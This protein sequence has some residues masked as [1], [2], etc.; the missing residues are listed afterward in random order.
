MSFSIASGPRDVEGV[1]GISGLPITSALRRCV[2]ARLLAKD[3]TRTTALSNLKI[4][5]FYFCNLTISV[6]NRFIFSQWLLIV[7]RDAPLI[8]EIFVAHKDQSFD[9][10]QM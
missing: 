2:L 4:I 8:C 6:P 10:V 9:A 1:D 3:G 7:F 5:F